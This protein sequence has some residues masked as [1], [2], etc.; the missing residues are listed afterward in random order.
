MLIIEDRAR[1]FSIKCDDQPRYSIRRVHGW[2]TYRVWDR[3]KA[4]WAS[5]PLTTHDEAATILKSL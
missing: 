5:E 3:I 2:K 1:Y 4:D